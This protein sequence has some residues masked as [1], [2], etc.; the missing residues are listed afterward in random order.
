M[1][2]TAVVTHPDTPDALLTHLADTTPP[3]PVLQALLAREDLTPTGYTQ[4]LTSLLRH[5]QLA[6]PATPPTPH[7]PL[8]T[9]LGSQ[10]T[11]APHHIWPDLVTTLGRHL[12][13]PTAHAALD[14]TTIHAPSPQSVAHKIATTAHLDANVRDRA[15]TY[16]HHARALTSA[17]L[18][19]LVDVRTHR[20][21][22][23]PHRTQGL[24]GTPSALATLLHAADNPYL[25]ETTP[26]QIAARLV[27]NLRNVLTV[28]C[29]FL[30]SGHRATH[31]LTAALGHDQ[32]H[33]LWAAA[34]AT[35]TLPYHIRLEGMRT[36]LNQHDTHLPPGS[37]TD[38]LTDPRTPPALVESY[39][40]NH[41]RL[42]LPTAMTLALRGDLST[43]TVTT[44]LAV[45]DKAIPGRT[46][47][48]KVLRAL[49]THSGDTLPVRDLTANLPLPD[50][51]P[52]ALHHTL[53]PLLR[54]IRTPEAA[55][56]LTAL[57][58]EFP[59]T[60]TDLFTTA[61]TISS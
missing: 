32:D 14:R 29:V 39:L 8:S 2:W 41:P 33:L 26:D 12:D 35:P 30:R 20:P 3:G 61:A 47:L 40:T 21:P 9:V 37:V 38:L 13:T 27:R 46:I 58:P 24:N 19:A 34:T 48:R 44:T 16:L 56:V 57:A 50:R 18:A 54:T 4:A 53:T 17:H 22:P 59:G 55:E 45:V 28:Q 10:L 5:L 42:D 25:P 51:T 52:S 6:P 11:T 36:S 15:L 43:H 23:T 1:L 49:A 31:V 60:L 7:T